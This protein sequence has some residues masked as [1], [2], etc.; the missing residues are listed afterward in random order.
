[1]PT[2]TG[3]SF[4][5]GSA[6][7]FNSEYCDFDLYRFRIYE[8]GLT[9]PQVIHNYLSDMHSI[10]LFDQNQIT[11]PLDPTALSYELLVKYNQDNPDML[12]MPYATWQIT[13]GNDELLPWKKGNNRV[14]TIDF[15][16]P[17]LD[18]DLEEVS[19]EFKLFIKQNKAVSVI[20]AALVFA[21][22]VC[23]TILLVRVTKLKNANKR[24]KKV[25]KSP[26]QY[27]R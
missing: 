27:I 16:N 13:D 9:M 22:I 11:D 14:A 20:A 12:S 7:Q 25:R 5:I 6:F 24:R 15:V 8:L 18:H 21:I 4:Q 23:N 2:G 3:S 26:D 19:K 10:T 17:S 1:M